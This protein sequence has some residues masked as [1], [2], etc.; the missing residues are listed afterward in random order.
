MRIRISL[1]LLVLSFASCGGDD[2]FDDTNLLISLSGD[3]NIV[4]PYRGVKVDGEIV[5]Y[6]PIQTEDYKVTISETGE[7][8]IYA[9]ED[10]GGFLMGSGTI[11]GIAKKT[12]VFDEEL[13]EVLYTISNFNVHAP[14]KQYKIVDRDET[15]M[16]IQY[17]YKVDGTNTYEGFFLERRMTK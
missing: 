6:V 15:S 13:A 9:P 7:V 17:V 2:E 4:S 1:L 11:K 10:D 3:W 8:S 16:E 14:K 5:K 12:L